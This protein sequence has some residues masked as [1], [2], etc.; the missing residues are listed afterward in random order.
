[1]TTRVENSRKRFHRGHHY[2]GSPS[3]KVH[4]GLKEKERILMLQVE[5]RGELAGL[6]H[7][8]CW[9]ILPKDIQP[10]ELEQA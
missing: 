2:H 8:V 5:K 10:R 3:I 4:I 9:L 1:M 6:P 7:T